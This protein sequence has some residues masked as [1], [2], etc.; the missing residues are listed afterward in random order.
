MS[1]DMKPGEVKPVFIVEGVP[2][3]EVIKYVS[4]WLKASL[5]S[6]KRVVVHNLTKSSNVKISFQQ[7]EMH[8]TVTDIE[9]KF[10]NED[11]T[12]HEQQKEE[13]GAETPRTTEETKTE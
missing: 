13:P 5:P 3:D 12:T 10:Y 2:F 9:F 11:P 6:V 1:M 4:S 8:I 7:S